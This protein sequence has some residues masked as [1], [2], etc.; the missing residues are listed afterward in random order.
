MKSIHS[1]MGNL[2]Y[3]STVWVCRRLLNDQCSKD[4]CPPIPLFEWMVIH[5]HT[6]WGH[7]AVYITWLH[8]HHPS[9]GI[10]VFD[11]LKKHHVN[12]M[13]SFWYLASRL[14]V[15]YVDEIICFVC[16]SYRTWITRRCC[17]ICQSTQDSRV[18]SQE[19]TATSTELHSAQTKTSAV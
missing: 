17:Q 10:K 15:P 7:Y 11:Y 3:R 16:R 2:Q 6:T 19:G 18:Q 14:V 13:Y 5:N 12:N 8:R 9:K 4:T 1:V